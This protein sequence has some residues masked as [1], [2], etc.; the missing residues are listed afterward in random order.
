MAGAARHTLA[1]RVRFGAKPA[2][3][4]GGSRTCEFVADSSSEAVNFLAVG[5]IET[6]KLPTRLILRACESFDR[7]RSWALWLHTNL[8]LRSG[9]Q[10]SVSKDGDT[11]EVAKSLYRRAFFDAVLV[12]TLRDAS[13]R[14][15]G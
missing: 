5:E 14:S 9:A 2:D 3:C 13:L 11:K 7:Q 8:I 6:I 4:V 15:S 12:A 10:R 1:I